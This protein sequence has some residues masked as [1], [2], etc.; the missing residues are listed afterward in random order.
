M[1]FPAQWRREDVQKTLA[2]LA[3]HPNVARVA[4]PY[5][6]VR[7]GAGDLGDVDLAL[8][9][10]RLAGSSQLGSLFAADG[11]AR[12]SLYLRDIGLHS[13]EETLEAVARACPVGTC[14]AAGDL[15]AYAEFQ[16]RVPSTLFRGFASSLLLVGAVLVGLTWALGLRGAGSVLLAAFWGPAAMVVVLWA[17]QVPLT[18]LT[19]VFASALVGL[20]GDNP[21]QCLFAA[22]RDGLR[23]GLERR[24]GAALQV[25][26]VMGLAALVFVGSS[27]VPSRQLGALL[28]LGFMTAVVGDLWLLR[29]LLT[30]SRRRA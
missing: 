12:A 23:A 2:Q 29:A 28:A 18:F 25:A 9:R 20:T 15:V 10:P 13:L 24:G 30:S 19:C 26:L 21:I 8:L 1:V 11:R 6:L 5:E 17:L 16:S 22:R 3:R 4:D 27:F 7:F 14:R